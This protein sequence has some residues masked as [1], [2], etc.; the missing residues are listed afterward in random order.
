MLVQ[1]PSGKLSFKILNRMAY[2]YVVFPMCPC[3]HYWK[4]SIK[5]TPPWKLTTLYFTSLSLVA[6]CFIHLLLRSK[7]LALG[8]VNFYYF[9]LC[10]GQGR[11]GIRWSPLCH[12]LGLGLVGSLEAA[13]SSVK[14]TGAIHTSTKFQHGETIIKRLVLWICR[15]I[16]NCGQWWRVMTFI[17]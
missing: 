11:Q 12:C 2:L 17:L 10:L 3:T 5:H 1:L 14:K 6:Q 9:N 7:S 4:D 13:L 16:P 8:I 15:N